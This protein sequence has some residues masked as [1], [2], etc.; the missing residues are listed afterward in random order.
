MCRRNAQDFTDYMSFRRSDL[1]GR[2][3][4]CVD[5]IEGGETSIQVDCSDMTLEE[6][7]FFKKELQRRINNL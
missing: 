6:Q 2:V 4:K 7:E 3:Q 1:E 5:A